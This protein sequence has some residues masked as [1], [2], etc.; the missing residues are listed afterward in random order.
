MRVEGLHRALRALP[1]SGAAIAPA[2]WKRPISAVMGPLSEWS[3][4]L[5]VS[6]SWST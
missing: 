2:L 1:A 3:S 5:G 6:F 4:Q